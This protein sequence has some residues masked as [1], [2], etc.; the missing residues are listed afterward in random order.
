MRNRNYVDPRS[1]LQSVLSMMEGHHRF[2][3]RNTGRTYDPTVQKYVLNPEGVLSNNRHFIASTQMEYQPNGDA[4]SEGQTIHVLGYCYAYL[5]TGK[6]AYLDE[7]IQAWDSYVKYFYKGQPIPDTPQ[8]WICNWII[9]GKEPCVANWPINPV[10]PTQ[11]GYKCVPIEFVNGRGRIPHG[12]PFW[13]EYLDVFTF[14]HRG[15]MGWGSINASVRPLAFEV[16]WQDVYDNYRVSEMPKEPWIQTVWVDWPRYFKDKYPGTDMEYSV[17]W[18]SPKLPEY[19]AEWIVAWTN[20]RIGIER[21]PDDQ[22]WSGEILET[23]LPDEDKGL[24]QLTDTSINGVY[25]VNYAVRLPPE[26]GGYLFSRNEPWHNRPV[27]T[28]LLGSINQLGNAADAELWFVDASYLLWKI[29]GEERFR[30]A[31]EASLFT[32]K[33]YTEIDTKDKFFRKSTT[34]ATPYT[35]GISYGFTYP[36]EASYVETRSDDGYIKVI[37]EES[38]QYSIEQ[39]AVWYRINQASKVRTEFGGVGIN[40]APV[41]ATVRVTISLDKKEENGELW[42][43]SLPQ[44]TSNE[45]I[46]YD[47]SFADMAKMYNE[48][49]G[50][51]ILADSR[52]VTDHGNT[53]WSEMVSSNVVDTRTARV[54]KA[55]YPNH[56]GGL[57]I[58]FWLLPEEVA[59][60]NEIAYR[61]DAPMHLRV[62]DDDGWKWYWLLPATGEDWNVMTLN[63]AD[64]QLS[65][66]QGEERENIPWPT[67][68]VFDKVDQ[69]EVILANTTDTDKDFYFYALNGVP[70][71]YLLEDGYTL[72]YR[73]TLSCPEPFVGYIGD[74]KV[75]DFRDDSLAYTPGTIPFSN[76]YIEGSDQF[77]SWHGMPYPGYQYPLIYCIEREKYERELNNMIDFLYDAQIAYHEATGVL[78]PVAAAYVWNRWDNFSY[79]E[80]DTFT[81]YHWGDGNPW[82]G[83]QPRAFQGAARAWQELV[84]RGESVPPKLVAYVENWIRWLIQFADD[85]GFFPTS[86]PPEGPPPAIE[87]DF[88]GHM[89]GLFLAGMCMAHMAGCRIPGLERA[90]E[91]CV[92]DIQRNYEVRSDPDDPMNGSWSPW[93]GGG[94][95]FGFW[96]GEILRGLGMYVLYRT[97]TIENYL[98]K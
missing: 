27:H 79:G 13:G 67:S 69:V 76:I 57:I 9:N 78:G 42:G 72:K 77:D 66:W 51:Y 24:V 74:C 11:G 43:Y 65:T 87:D 22:L 29:T 56:D 98:H 50:E 23:D 31:M 89:S 34:A 40:G 61:A 83:Y 26:K 35:D 36:S 32:I 28:P 1:S 5:A 63:K 8:R 53:F 64:I 58:G 97:R 3:K 37:T 6:K 20:N 2:L 16:D 95:F 44:S 10:A 94:M 90:I 19:G 55:T 59:P 15:A 85:N 62:T 48:D 21:G 47:T 91:I 75:V 86:F 4:T 33:E 68:P 45:V 12:A 70:P 54:I 41:S 93:A 82:S 92:N 25:F 39:Q 30:K 17:D 46:T 7:A 52:S 84:Y 49:G 73:L 80:P 96:A 71:T 38:M 81:M 60:V 18:S 88:T 14:A